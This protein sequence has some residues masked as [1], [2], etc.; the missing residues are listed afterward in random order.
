MNLS[1]I[2]TLVIHASATKAGVWI[3]AADIDRMHKARGWRKIGYHRVIRL[4]GSVEQ[5]RLF[6]EQGAHVAGNNVNTIGVCMIGGLDADGNPANTFTPDQ[7]HSLYAEI[8]NIRNL[9]PNITRICGHRDFSPDLNGDGIITPDEWIKDCPCFD[10]Q[11]K[12]DEWG[13]DL[14]PDH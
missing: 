1:D 2:H 13:I 12:L 11:A 3:T 10:V 6:T 5:G 4:D 9:C 14:N 7:Y 8:I